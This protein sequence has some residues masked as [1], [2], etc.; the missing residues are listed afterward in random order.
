MK[1]NLTNEEKINKKIKDLYSSGSIKKDRSIFGLISLMVK[2]SNN[3]LK[4]AKLAFKTSDNQKLKESLGLNKDDSFFD[5]TIIT[6]YYSMYFITHALLATKG[7]KIKKIR[8]HESTLFAFAKY[9]ILS[10]EL[11]DELFLIYEDAE[12]KAEELFTTLSEEKDKRV[13]FTYERLPKANR[14]PAKESIENASKF[15][16]EIESIIKSKKYV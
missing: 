15:L 1:I 7:I 5:W 12:S 4:F 6:A 14:Q 3:N 11:E 2:K 13:H 8:V 10:K 16:R 9:F